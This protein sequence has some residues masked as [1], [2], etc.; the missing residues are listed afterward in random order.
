MSENILTVKDI[1]KNFPGVQA[2][3]NVSLSLKKGEVL[4]LVGENGGAGKSTLMK[5]IAGVY[6]PDEGKIIYQ[7][8]EKNGGILLSP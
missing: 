3:K 2:L 1:S 7:G 6:T 4:G 8:K 5:I